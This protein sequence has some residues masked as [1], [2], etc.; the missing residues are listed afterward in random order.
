[1]GFGVD[2]VLLGL[3][4]KEKTKI[5]KV[6]HFESLYHLPVWPLIHPVWASMAMRNPDPHP[7]PPPSLDRNRSEG[8]RCTLLHSYIF[9]LQMQD[10][11]LPQATHNL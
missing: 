4:T 3:T 10:S 11:L 5:D 6:T 8:A 9:V 2:Q 7:S 1:M